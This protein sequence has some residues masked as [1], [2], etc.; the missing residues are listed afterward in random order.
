MVLLILCAGA[1]I[2]RDQSRQEAGLWQQQL[3][4][5]SE[6]YTAIKMVY[7]KDVEDQSLIFA[8]IS[9][10]L[11]SLDPH[12]YFMD[13]VAVRSMYE[14]Q[15][16]NYFG[17]GIRITKYED[18]LT[19]IAPLP[20]TPAYEM[21]ILAGD[22]VVEIEGKDTRN[23]SL[24]EAM[25]YLRGAKDTS[26]SIKI[27][28]D[29]IAEPIP[30]TIKRTEIP[31]NSVSYALPLLKHPEI[32]YISIRT[33]GNTTE[34]EFRDSLEKL[35]G[36]GHIKGLIIDLRGNAG[37]ALNAA[38]ALSELFLDKGRLIVSIR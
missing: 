27:H 9:G 37:G 38:L 36:Q 25:R 32:G 21:G 34:K 6:I 14:D 18:R 20:G 4:K 19:V 23:L 10:L 3:R 11:R 30:F 29:G 26:V 7:P 8:S 13:P 35:V 5:F 16:G 22:V 33:F 15:Q 28:R 31:L 24:D 2:S 12:S 1:V 17:I